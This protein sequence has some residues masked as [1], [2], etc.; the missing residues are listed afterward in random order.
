MCAANIIIVEKSK[1]A[2]DH[3]MPLGGRRRVF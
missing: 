3:A 2:L 1:T